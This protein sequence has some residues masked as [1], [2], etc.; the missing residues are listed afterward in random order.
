M[1]N[2]ILTNYCN[3][4]CG[5]CFA[6]D[7]RIRTARTVPAAMSDEEFDGWLDFV[8]EAGIRELRLLGGEPTLHPLF[9]DFVRKGRDAGMSVTVFT[10]GLIPDG[11]LNALA[12]LDPEVCTVVVNMNAAVTSDEQERRN[13]SLRILGSRV[14]PGIT[15]ISPDFTLLPVVSAIRAYGLNPLIRI[16]L[17][18]PTRK[19]FNHALHPK[20]YSALGQ[21]LFEQSFLTAKYGIGMDADCGF[22]RCMFGDKFSQ[23]TANGFRYA[24]N[25]T[26]VLDLCTGNVV[27]PCFALSNLVQ[28]DGRNF[29]HEG[30]AYE[31]LTEMLKPFHNFGIYPECAECAYFE[32][33]SCCG[34]CLAAR[35]RRMRAPSGAQITTSELS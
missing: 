14:T 10:N 34:G 2:L 6:A 4:N 22:V 23:L 15:L 3:A 26:P 17:S 18:H 5:F 8:R 20:R 30:E 11:A 13:H 29:R 9:V 28:L 35:L 24:S 33:E 31:R 7:F 12:G 19:G 32:T 16:G 25:C 1:A 21:A 27:L